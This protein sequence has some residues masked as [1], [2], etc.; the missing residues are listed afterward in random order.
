VY[1]ARRNFGRA[2]G[3]PSA[4]E[5]SARRAGGMRQK[6]CGF[7]DGLDLTFSIAGRTGTFPHECQ[8][9]GLADA[10]RLRHKGYF[11]LSE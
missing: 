3:A 11:T 8:R 9:Y 1:A 5:A 10:A 7:M 4:W 2:L 6:T